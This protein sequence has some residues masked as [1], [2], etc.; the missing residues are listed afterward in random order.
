MPRSQVS[1]RLASWRVAAMPRSRS[2]SA[3][4]GRAAS[5]VQRLP[6]PGGS[7]RSA[8]TAVRRAGRRARAAHALRPPGRRPASASKRCA[9]RGCSHLRSVGFERDQRG[10][11]RMACAAG[12]CRARLDSGCPVRRYTSSARWM[13][14][15]S[16]RRQ[17][18]GRDR[19][20]T[21]QLGVQSPA[22]PRSRACASSV[23]AQRGVGRGQRVQALEQCLE[24]QHRPAHQQR[25]AAAGVDLRISRRASATK[26]AAEYA[27]GRLDHVDQ[28][29]RH[30]GAFGGAG[31]G[32][33]DVHAAV[34]QRRIDADDLQRPTDCQRSGRAPVRRRIL[35]EAVGPAR[36]RTSGRSAAIR[37][38]GCTGRAAA[39]RHAAAPVSRPPQRTP[40]PTPTPSVS[41]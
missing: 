39:G 27:L 10:R 12:P 8:S 17:A 18:G 34:H 29:V 31:F 15:A 26:R 30:R 3:A 25:Q 16:R 21:R 20:D 38:A 5:P 13:R 32:G 33:A 41:G 7:R 40:R 4:A 11:S 2:R 19:V 1:C 24:I 6:R 14:C 23:G 28:V 9:M 35:P 36:H 37:S 22:S